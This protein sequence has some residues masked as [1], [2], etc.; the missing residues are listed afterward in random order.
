MINMENMVPIQLYE[1]ATVKFKSSCPII[2]ELVGV[3]NV[4]TIGGYDVFTAT[5]SGIYRFENTCGCTSFYEVR[6]EGT[7][8]EEDCCQSQLVLLEEIRDAIIGADASNVA[9]IQS[10]IATIDDGITAVVTIDGQPVDVNVVTSAPVTGTVA[11]DAATLAALENITVLIDGQPIDVAVT[12]AVTVN[13]TVTA[14]IDTAS[15]TA[16]ANA[17][18][19]ETLTVDD[20]AIIAAIE[21][22]DDALLIE[23]QTLNVTQPLILAELQTLNANFALMMGKNCANED[24]FRV[25]DPCTTDTDGDGLTDAQEGILGTDANN[26]DTDG[27]GLTDDEEVNTTNTDPQNPDTDG[28]GVDDGTEVAAGLDPNDS[29]DD[30]CIDCL[31]PDFDVV[32]VNTSTRKGGARAAANACFTEWRSSVNDPA[33]GYWVIPAN[34]TCDVSNF[35]AI[36]PVNSTTVIYYLAP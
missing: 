22:S 30:I 14:V 34:T 9:A 25:F 24:A 27:D 6:G 36:T 19:G 16:L 8:S 23:L 31:A 28:G 15:I 13:G 29:T 35:V 2:V 26:P 3:N 32:D 4:A 7:P 18:A 11:L 10:L 1:G 17:I 33:Q 5:T 21:A 20:A 12:N